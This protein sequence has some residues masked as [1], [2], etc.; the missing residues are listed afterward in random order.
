VLVAISAFTQV[1][2]M[3]KTCVRECKTVHNW[4]ASEYYSKCKHSLF[5]AEKIQSTSIE[6]VCGCQ[7][8]HFKS[9]CVCLCVHMCR[10]ILKN[11]HPYLF[12][13]RYKNCI[14]VHVSKW[15]FFV[16]LTSLYIQS[17][18]ALRK[19]DS[20]P[21]LR[22]MCTIHIRQWILVIGKKRQH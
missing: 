18:P 22:V 16:S 4:K 14:R 5:L 3:F 13:Q 15:R 7:T 17:V 2:P 9:P 21:T 19:V 6:S 8:L 10:S 20:S 12:P 11:M 1:R